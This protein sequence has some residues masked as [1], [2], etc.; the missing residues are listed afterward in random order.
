[1][2]IRS[3]R[4]GLDSAST[5]AVVAVAVAAL[6]FVAAVAV[7][8]ATGVVAPAAVGL[9]AAGRCLVRRSVFPRSPDCG[10]AVCRA[11]RA[12]CTEVP[13]PCSVVA[14]GCGSAAAADSCWACFEAALVD[15]AASLGHYLVAVCYALVCHSAACSAS[16]WLEAHILPLARWRCC[17]CCS[18]ASGSRYAEAFVPNSMTT[19][20]MNCCCTDHYELGDGGDVVVAAAVMAAAAMLG[21]VPALTLEAAA[22]VDSDNSRAD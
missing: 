5:D 7:V 3:V 14:A 22:T 1:M 20:E 2:P 13:D 4:P 9:V 15:F 10:S 12:G 6:C 17:S 21:L 16:A 19:T 11:D 18:T 8:V